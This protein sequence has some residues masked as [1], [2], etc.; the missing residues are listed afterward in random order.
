MIQLVIFDFDGVFTDGKIIFEF[1][2]NVKSIIFIS[3]G[4]PMK[5]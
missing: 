4:T 3:I 1:Y 2:P 5:S